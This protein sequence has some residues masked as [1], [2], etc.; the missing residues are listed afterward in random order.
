MT[1][2]NGI[3]M[4]DMVDEPEMTGGDL[5]TVTNDLIQACKDAA[6]WLSR[7]TRIDD[8]EQAQDLRAA[9]ARAEGRAQ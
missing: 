7:S 5:E 6:D 1:T 3:E 9:I 4:E 8:Q 2:I